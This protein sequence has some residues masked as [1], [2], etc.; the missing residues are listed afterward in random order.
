MRLILAIYSALVMV[1]K[2]VSN[3]KEANQGIRQIINDI[4]KDFENNGMKLPRISSEVKRRIKENFDELQISD[5]TVER[6]LDPKYKRP[7]KLRQL[8]QIDSIENEEKK[9]IEVSTYGVQFHE[10]IESKS[11]DWI[12]PT[13]GTYEYNKSDPPIQPKEITV[14]YN[15]FIQQLQEKDE[16]I[17]TQQHKEPVRIVMNADFFYATVKYMQKLVQDNPNAQ[18]FVLEYNPNTKELFT[19]VTEVNEEVNVF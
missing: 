16:I 6:A 11:D 3:L 15:D 19:D 18:K 1:E 4:A 17:R 14:P 9:E 7:Q 10:P 8:S 5:R 2:H 12:P 13:D